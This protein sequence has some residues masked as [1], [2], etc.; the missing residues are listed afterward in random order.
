[1]TKKPKTE[2]TAAAGPSWLPRLVRPYDIGTVLA[3]ISSKASEQG[4]DI[5]E[6]SG[7]PNAIVEGRLYGTR[8]YEL[9]RYDEAGVFKDDLE[10]WVF[11]A[12]QAGRGDETAQKAIEFLR[13]NSPNEYNA[14][15]AETGVV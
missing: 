6:A 11:V 8:P 9:E 3:E 14:I 5:F 13:D 7:D 12:K 15:V 4:W 2:E 10:A 1:M